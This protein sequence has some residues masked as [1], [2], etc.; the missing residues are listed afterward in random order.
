MT[1]FLEIPSFLDIFVS[2]LTRSLSS[3]AEVRVL[4]AIIDV[5]SLVDVT[6]IS[7]LIAGV[8]LYVVGF[9]AVFNVV[10][11]IDVFNSFDVSFVINYDSNS[12]W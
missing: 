3:L 4:V 10:D 6:I 2:V 9:L 1:A 5:F 12:G 11:V 8:K 7:L